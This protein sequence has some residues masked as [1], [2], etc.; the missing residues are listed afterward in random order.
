MITI[1]L[2]RNGRTESATSIDRGWLNPAA[3]LS[4]WVDLTA[5]SIPESLIL[6][7]T[8]AFHRLAVDDAMSSPQRAKVDAYDGYL[9]SVFHAPDGEVKCFVGPAFVVSVHRDESRAIADLADSIRHDGKA[10]AEGPVGLWHRIVGAGAESHRPVVEQ[11]AACVDSVEQRLFEK[12]T[13]ALV[14]EMLDLR[15]RLYALRQSA[16]AQRE[17]VDRLVQ[18]ESMDL[19]VEMAYRFRDV[20]DRLAH[21]TDEAA[22]LEDRLAGALAAGAGLAGGRRWM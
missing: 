10:M 4:L 21:V 9:L 7:D 14:R 19:S 11:L 13:P 22:A 3:G 20:G 15:R 1:F 5:P 17:V 2:H 8:F 6:S 12:A 16:R 18:R